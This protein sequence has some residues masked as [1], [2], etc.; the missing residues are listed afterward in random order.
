L[1]TRHFNK[2]NASFLFL[3]LIFNFNL[4][5]ILGNYKKWRHDHKE[6][7]GSETFPGTPKED[8]R[9]P[10][11]FGIPGGVQFKRTPSGASN[12]LFFFPFIFLFILQEE[13]SWYT[14]DDMKEYFNRANI[15]TGIEL[16]SNHS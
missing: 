6:A 12:E 7:E 14:P 9:H 13:L 16:S 15:K 3:F 8:H 2:I 4:F 5:L 10:V 11:P 1:C